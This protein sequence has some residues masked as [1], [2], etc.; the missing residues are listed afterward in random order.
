MIPSHASLSLNHPSI[1]HMHLDPSLRPCSWQHQPKILP[2]L[3]FFSTPVFDPYMSEPHCTVD[4]IGS[5]KA[6]YLSAL[7]KIILFV[8]NKLGILTLES[9]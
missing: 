2:I 9:L 6:I 4:K 5:H 7:S 1:N 3:F 8:G